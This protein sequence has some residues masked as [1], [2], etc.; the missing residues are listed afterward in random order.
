MLNNQQIQ[1]CVSVQ[2]F[3]EASRQFRT[4]QRIKDREIKKL[5]E[6]KKG[7]RER[8]NQTSLCVDE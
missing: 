5:F 2:L 4:D 7:K 1:K 8:K 3:L 6:K